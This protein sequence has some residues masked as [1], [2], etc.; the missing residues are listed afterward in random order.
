M[1]RWVQGFLIIYLLMFTGIFT[2]TAHASL[3]ISQP[4]PGAELDAAPN[5]V[6]VSFSD[7]I[8]EG[9]FIRVIN[10]Q[11]R[12]VHQGST[13]LGVNRTSMFVELT[14]LPPGKYAVNWHA[15]AQDGDITDGA[16]SF[17]VNNPLTRYVPFIVALVALI[18]VELLR[19]FGNKAEHK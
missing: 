7:I 6:H 14:A 13:F 11:F 12:P 2:V 8:Q 5:E 15:I 10:E 9:S 16:Y 4:P 18:A 17:T 3:T 1:Y 19:R